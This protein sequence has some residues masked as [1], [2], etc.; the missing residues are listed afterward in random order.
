MDMNAFRNTI[1]SGAFALTTVDIFHQIMLLSSGCSQPVQLASMLVGLPAA[2]VCGT[3]I[4]HALL[5]L[6]RG[7]PFLTDLIDYEPEPLF[8]L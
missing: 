5:S 8:L 4:A 6:W 2:T 7:T 3:L 1:V